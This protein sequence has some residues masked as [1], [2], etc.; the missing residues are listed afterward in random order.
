MFKNWCAYNCYAVPPCSRGCYGR[1]GYSRLPYDQD[2][3]FRYRYDRDAI[4]TDNG[5]ALAYPITG[6][7]IMR[8]FERIY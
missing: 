1:Y 8:S 5:L 6:E 2:L 3:P 4:P 7:W